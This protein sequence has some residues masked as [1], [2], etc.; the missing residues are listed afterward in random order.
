[1]KENVSESSDA[2]IV[3]DGAMDLTLLNKNQLL[4]CT[5]NDCILFY[6]PISIYALIT[7][8]SKLILK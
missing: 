8:W 2:I 7:N 6:I 3:S 5:F 1:M 4:K